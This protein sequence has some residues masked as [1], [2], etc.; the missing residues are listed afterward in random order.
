VIDGSILEGSAHIHMMSGPWL[1]LF[2]SSMEVCF[3]ASIRS[4]TFPYLC[5]SLALCLMLS[6]SFIAL[7]V[8]H[9]L[10]ACRFACTEKKKTNSE[11]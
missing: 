6:V 7:S 2:Q 4:A 10:C 8:D 5:T 1:L 9:H 11:K 3:S